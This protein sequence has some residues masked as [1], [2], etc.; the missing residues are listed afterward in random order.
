MLLNEIVP[1]FHTMIPTRVSAVGHEDCD[2]LIQD[3]TVMAV[4]MLES[5][6]RR[7]KKVTAGTIAHYTVLHARCGRR[8]KRGQS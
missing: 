6:E 3:C 4:K 8:S 5:A 1:R 2:E 7:G